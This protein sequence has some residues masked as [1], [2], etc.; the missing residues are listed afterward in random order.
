MV[1]GMRSSKK[2]PPEP[3][4]FT[5]DEPGKVRSGLEERLRP[6]L[7]SKPALRRTSEAASSAPPDLALQGKARDIGVARNAYL[8]A[9]LAAFAWGGTLLAYTIGYVGGVAGLVRAP[10]QLA[11]IALMIVLPAVFIFA[12]AYA[13]RQGARLAAEAR[14]TRAMAEDFVTPAALAASRAGEI[15]EIVRNEVERVSASTLAAHGQ[16]IALREALGGETERLTDAAAQAQHTAR[17]VGETL[18]RERHGVSELLAQLDR[19][20]AG[21]AS[22]VERQSRLVGE[23]SD[24]ARSQ[25]QE[26]EAT[27]ASGAE[28]MAAAA[29]DAGQAGRQAAEDLARQAEAPDGRRLPFAAVPLQHAAIPPVRGGDA[30]LPLVRVRRAGGGH[31][32]GPARP[33]QR[34]EDPR[35]RHRSPARRRRARHPLDVLGTP[36]AGEGP[37]DP[38]AA[39]PRA[40]AADPD[41]NTTRSS[42]R[43]APTSSSTAS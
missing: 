17:V 6:S 13:L 8:F 5:P 36:A 32:Q 31:R 29:G 2:R 41:P 37:D 20:T 10:M 39:V 43:C 25:L 18:T 7:Q 35:P 16:L 19:D 28:R 27:L 3:L 14:W 22:G 30:R 9:W 38:A 26:A 12:G 24:L 23:A 42:R 4:N 1:L 40:A 33:R 21:L 15:A 11:V 34:P